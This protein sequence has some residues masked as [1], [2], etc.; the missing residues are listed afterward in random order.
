M[1]HFLQWW[2]GNNSSC[3]LWFVTKH[4]TRYKHYF[5]TVVVSCLVT[6]RG[7]QYNYSYEVREGEG[8]VPGLVTT[9]VTICQEKLLRVR[10]EFILLGHSISQFEDESG[11]AQPSEGCRPVISLVMSHHTSHLQSPLAFSHSRPQ[12]STLNTRTA[13]HRRFNLTDSLEWLEIIPVATFT[14]WFL[15]S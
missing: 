8:D 7:Q 3:S 13:T 14:L 11:L 15:K 2:C 4:S 5:N 10:G 12:Q 1:S 6:G 9:P